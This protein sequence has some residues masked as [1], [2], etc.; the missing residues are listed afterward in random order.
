M[1]KTTKIEDFGLV[2]GGVWEAKI[3]DFRTFFD[4]S[5]SFYKRGSEGEKIDQK[6]EK[7]KLFRFL[8]QGRR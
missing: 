2:L 1:E 7:T 6:F 5:I 4:I 3:I 8:A